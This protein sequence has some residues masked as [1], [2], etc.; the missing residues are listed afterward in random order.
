MTAR[1]RLLADDFPAGEKNI[2][3]LFKHFFSFN[4]GA[5][6]DALSGLTLLS[7][8]ETLRKVLEGFPRS[9]PSDERAL[10]SDQPCLA[11]HR[12]LGW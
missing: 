2:F 6:L 3:S 11:D 1:A 5:S 8:P 4:G 10:G 7:F 12:G 9:S